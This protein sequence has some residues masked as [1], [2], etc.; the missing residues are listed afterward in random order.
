MMI[1]TRKRG[2]SSR[3]H[4]RQF[5]STHT[6]TIFTE[7][8]PL[9]S[10]QASDPDDVAETFCSPENVKQ[11]V[12]LFFTSY[13][14]ILRE[15]FELSAM[16]VQ[17]VLYENNSSRVVRKKIVDWFADDMSAVYLPPSKGN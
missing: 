16:K 11:A 12:K 15:H 5:E 1:R 13:F 17:R 2:R 6:K 8:Q 10:V 7:C 9:R 3:Q 4:S 14:D